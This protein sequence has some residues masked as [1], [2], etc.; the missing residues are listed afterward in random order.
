M[1]LQHK[2]PKNQEWPKHQH[3]QHLFKCYRKPAA[4]HGPLTWPLLRQSWKRDNLRE[5]MA[6]TLGEVYQRSYFHADTLNTP[7]WSRKRKA[8]YDIQIL[9]EVYQDKWDLTFKLIKL[10]F[11]SIM[12]GCQN[13]NDWPTVLVISLK[14]NFLCLQLIFNLHPIKLHFIFWYAANFTDVYNWCQ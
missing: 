3:H 10:A 9:S 14:E 5:G 1:H 4:N 12:L 8:N 7:M 11:V 13:D 6:Q 2:F